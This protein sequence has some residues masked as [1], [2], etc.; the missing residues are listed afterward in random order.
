MELP[1][2][3]LSDYPL[4]VSAGARGNAVLAVSSFVLPL[5][6]LAEFEVI[7]NDKPYES[8]ACRPISSG[9]TQPLPLAKGFPDDG[10]ATRQPTPLHSNHSKC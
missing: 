5:S 6:C 9:N 1:G 3:W 7:E 2:V 4:D 8:G 10:I